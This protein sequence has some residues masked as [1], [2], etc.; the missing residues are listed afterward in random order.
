MILSLLLNGCEG[1]LR[2]GPGPA[3]A[4][5]WVVEAQGVICWIFRD[6]PPGDTGGAGR[7]PLPLHI[8]QS[9]SDTQRGGGKKNFILD[10]FPPCGQSYDLEE[11]TDTIVGKE[12]FR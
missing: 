7:D 12:E 5:D 3:F 2:L 8:G 4:T 6:P 11:D 9:L 10:T 1:G